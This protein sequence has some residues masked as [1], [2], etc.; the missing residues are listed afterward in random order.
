MIGYYVTVKDGKRSGFLLGPFDD[1]AAALA[2]VDQ[3]RKLAEAADC[4]AAFYSF[5]TGRVEREILPLG[6]LNGRAEIPGL[7]TTR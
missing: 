1:H 4:R 2:R 3:A 5:G 7:Q 6:A